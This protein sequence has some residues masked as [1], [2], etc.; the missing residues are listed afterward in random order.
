[1]TKTIEHFQIEEAQSEMRTRVL[2]IRA[3][4]EDQ[5]TPEL[6]SERAT[7]DKKFAEG[8]I[9]FR[10]SLKAMKAEQEA[11]TPVDSAALELRQLTDRASVNGLGAIAAGVLS[12][13]ACEGERESFNRL[14][15]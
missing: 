10:A 4:P 15:T 1:M 7:L 8:E 12:G 13:H 2:E 9:K 6:R 3:I 5:L 11:G 14:T